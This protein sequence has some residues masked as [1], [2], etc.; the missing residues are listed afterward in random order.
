[1][2]FTLH[3]MLLYLLNINILHMYEISLIMLKI[4]VAGPTICLKIVANAIYQGP[5][6]ELIKYTYIRA[7]F[8]FSIIN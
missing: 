5:M 2:L 1:M 6:Q 3:V 8:K 7:L 4:P